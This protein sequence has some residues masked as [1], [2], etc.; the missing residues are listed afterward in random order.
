[1]SQSSWGRKRRR[2]REDERRHLAYIEKRLAEI[3]S[4]KEVQEGARM[5]EPV[6][7]GEPTPGLR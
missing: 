6:P 2:N 3:E 1:V 4:G 5:G 7:P